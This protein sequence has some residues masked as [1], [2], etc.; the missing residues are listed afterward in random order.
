MLHPDIE[1]FPNIIRKSFPN[2]N[3]RIVTNG[4]LLSKQ[5]ET[6][7]KSCRENN[8][9][10]EQTKYPIPINFESIAELAKSHNVKHIYMDNTNETTKTM[11]I[12]PI[13]LESMSENAVNSQNERLNFFNCWEANQCIRIQNG[14]IYTCSRIPHIHLLNEH[15]NLNYKV[16]DDDSIDIYA[17]KSK[18]EIYDFLA[19][20]V[21]FCR[22][23]KVHAISEGHPWKTSEQ[24]IDEW[25]N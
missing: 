2:V 12:F 14:R 4:I 11:Q 7:W 5:P 16:T 3:I 24:S 17:V 13:D 1:L 22:Y 6:F 15:F 21:P 9:V 23:C 20:A 10:L 19:S 18:K 25:A 8:V